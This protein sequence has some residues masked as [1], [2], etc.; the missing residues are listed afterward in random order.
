MDLK[1]DHRNYIQVI[2]CKIYIRNSPIASGN[3]GNANKKEQ[4]SNK[5]MYIHIFKVSDITRN[6]K[7]TYVC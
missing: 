6:E 2:Y 4:L 1:L 3:T 7:R 5:N